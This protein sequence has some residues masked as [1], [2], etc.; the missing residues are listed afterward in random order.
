KTLASNVHQYDP[1]LRLWSD[2]A[3]KTRWIYL[4]P[5]TKIDTSD[6][7]EWTFS[8]GTKIW[9]EFVVGGVRLETRLL[10][11]RP[12]APSHPTTYPPPRRGP[13]GG[14]GRRECTGGRPPPG[15]KTTKPPKQAIS[16]TCHTGRIDEV[17]GFEAVALSSPQASGVTM[18]TLTA[19]NLLTDPPT[20]PLT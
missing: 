12:T 2:G 11:K 17:L 7:N 3:S 14:P 19:A 9:K 13:P 15:A 8:P 10:W 1:G 6:M 16:K 5:G 20:S 4:P 18:A